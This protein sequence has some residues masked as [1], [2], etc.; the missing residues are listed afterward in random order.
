MVWRWGNCRIYR[1]QACRILRRL[2][3]AHNV[4]EEKKLIDQ[5]VAAYEKNGGNIRATATELGCSRSSV[6]RR[7]TKVGLGKKPLAGGTKEGTKTQVS[8]LPTAG[9]VKRYILT[10]AQNNTHVH[11]ELLANLEALADYYNAE[12]IVN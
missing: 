12:I 1:S 7:I 8:K 11:S 2:K 5:T 9:G 10:S 6:R 3:L 4:E